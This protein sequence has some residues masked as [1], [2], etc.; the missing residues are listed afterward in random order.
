MRLWHVDLIPYLPEA[1]LKGQH[2]ECC[3]L[4]GNGWGKKHKD[5]DYV[6]T[7]HPALLYNYH[8]AI[9][10]EMRARNMNVTE[11]WYDPT[12]RGDKCEPYAENEISYDGVPPRYP[13]HN[14]MYLKECILNLAE[15]GNEPFVYVASKVY[16]VVF[17]AQNK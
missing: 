3:G 8:L 6:F 11:V 1:Q 14:S 13:E 16:E 2:R 7:H 17:D 4:R 15:K 12:H 9:M 5:V 10:N